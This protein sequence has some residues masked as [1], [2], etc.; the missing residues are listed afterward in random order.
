MFEQSENN[1]LY[2]MCVCMSIV[3]IVWP[4]VAVCG[5]LS[6]TTWVWY[7]WYVCTVCKICFVHCTGGY[8]LCSGEGE[9]RHCDPV[10]VCVCVGVWGWCV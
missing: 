5:Y 9:R 3:M 1:L 7:T 6:N 4:C 8:Y 2:G 10:S